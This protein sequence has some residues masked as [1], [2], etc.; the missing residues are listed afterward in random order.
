ME[1]YTNLA[2]RH[3]YVRYEIMILI[4]THVQYSLINYRCTTNVTNET[5]RQIFQTDE[6]YYSNLQG[7]ETFVEFLHRDSFFSTCGF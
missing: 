7:R 4:I 3:N 2:H 1:P 5:Y 6:Y